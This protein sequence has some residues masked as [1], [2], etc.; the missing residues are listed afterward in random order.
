MPSKKQMVPQT[1]VKVNV[2]DLSE[3]VHLES[4]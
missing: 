2:L 1:Q 4:C 3:K